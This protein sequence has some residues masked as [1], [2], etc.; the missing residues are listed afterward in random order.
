[1]TNWFLGTMGFAYKQ[2]SGVF[3]PAGLNPSHYLAYYSERFTA[4]EVDATFYGPPRPEQVERWTAVTPSHFKFC[5]KT[6]RDI[7]HQQRLVNMLPAM[8]NFLAAMRLLGDKLGAILL[9][10]PPDFT[11]YEREKLVTFLK[12]LPSDIHFAVEFRD[13]SWDEPATADLL[14]TYNIAWVSADYI[15]LPKVVRQTADFL[16]LRFIGPHGQFTTKDRELIDKTA[17]LQNWQS[18]IQ[19]HLNKTDTIYGFF[20][21]DY[22]GYSPATC[23]RFKQIIGLETKDIRILQ[24]GRLF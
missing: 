15:Y 6:P 19:P 12:G 13:S 8:H 23:N 24:Q 10:F 1:M 18:Q 21:N 14:Q 4:V 7:T 3:Y 17:D 20:N 11:T 9:Q 5:A 22:A 16:Y 2:W